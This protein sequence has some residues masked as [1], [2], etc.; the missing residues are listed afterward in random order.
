MAKELA[1]R[2]TADGIALSK[3]TFERRG[4][5]RYVGQGYELRV[6]FPDG[7]LDEAALARAFEAFHEIHRREYGHHFA[8]S[9]IEI[10]NLRLVGAAAAAKIAKPTGGG[11]PIGRRGAGAQGH[12]HLQG[13][14]QARRLSDDF[15][16][17][18]LLPVGQKVA[19]PA[20]SCKWIR[21]P[22][23]RRSI[24]SQPTRPAIS[25]SARR[26]AN[27]HRASSRRHP[28]KTRPCGAAP[29]DEARLERPPAPNARR[30]R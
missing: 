11:R 22:S 30:I 9:G 23:C 13:R 4:D 12:L 19:G 20:S 3:V 16:R 14:E 28:S 26:P 29:Q 17:R 21:R 5:L 2:F 15:Y 18:D 25:A 1:A 6:P 24:V 10:V 27:E 8:E 7:T